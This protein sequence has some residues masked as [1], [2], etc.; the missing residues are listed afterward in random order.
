MIVKKIITKGRNIKCFQCKVRYRNNKGV[1]F[2][3]IKPRY[4]DVPRSSHITLCD[5]CL[6]DLYNKLKRVFK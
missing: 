6:Y 2:Y 4:I 5:S 3:I 1:G